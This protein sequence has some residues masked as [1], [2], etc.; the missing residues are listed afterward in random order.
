MSQRD[1]NLI[2]VITSTFTRVYSIGAIAPSNFFRVLPGG[3]I[4]HKYS[5]LGATSI[6]GKKNENFIKICP[7]IVNILWLIIQIFPSFDNHDVI[8]V[9]KI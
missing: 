4:A 3:G 8:K 9:I 7:K 1:A 2:L 6:R 5:R